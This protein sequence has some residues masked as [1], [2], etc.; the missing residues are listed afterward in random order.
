MKKIIQLLIFVIVLISIFFFYRIYLSKEIFNKS[1][2]TSQIK[3]ILQI[4]LATTKLRI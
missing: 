3:K 4:R 1:E 2:N